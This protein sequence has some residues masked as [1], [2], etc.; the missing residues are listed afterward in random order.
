MYTTEGIRVIRISNVQKGKIVDNDPKYYPMGKQDEISNFLLSEDDILISLTGNV[1]R[2]GRLTKDL[3]PAALNQRVAKLTISSTKVYDRYIYSLLNSEMFEQVA[4]ASSLGMAQLNMSTEWL[5]T[6]T[7]PL[8]E[9][10]RIAAIIEKK[11]ASV[12]KLK[13]HLAEQAE[14]INALPTAILRKAF[15][16]EV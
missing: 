7:I 6:F 9:Q 3:L 11:L 12:E 1:G 4:V 2:V 5:K 8:D 13:P 10:R 14:T 16:G 15:A